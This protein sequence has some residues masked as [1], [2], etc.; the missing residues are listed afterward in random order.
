MRQTLGERMCLCNAMRAIVAAVVLVV[1]KSVIAQE[2]ASTSRGTDSR[3]VVRI[4]TMDAAR[5]EQSESRPIAGVSVVA[6][7]VALLSDEQAISVE[8]DRGGRAILRV[9]DPGP[10][11][12]AGR[13][14]GALP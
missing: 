6:S 14:P 12:V 11:H 7:S 3:V 2:S 9:S 5:S 13:L 4:A 8:T 1:G 10:F